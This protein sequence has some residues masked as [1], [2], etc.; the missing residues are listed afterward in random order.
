MIDDR[1]KEILVICNETYNGK[2]GCK[3]CQTTATT[4]ITRIKQA[5]ADGYDLHA[6]NPFEGFGI[7]ERGVDKAELEHRV[8]ELQ[9]LV[10]FLGIAGLYDQ[11][12]AMKLRYHIDARTAQLRLELTK[13]KEKS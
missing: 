1:L 6:K 2:Q 4:Q 10:D 11:D 3:A 8:D 12:S 7:V 9:R 5:F 13:S